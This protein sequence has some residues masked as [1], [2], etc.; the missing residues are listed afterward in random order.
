MPLALLW[1]ADG[2]MRARP[3][4]TPSADTH[5]HVRA[6]M[7]ACRPSN[8]LLDEAGHAKLADFGIARCATTAI[9]TDDSA[10]GTAPC[11][12]RVRH[13]LPCP[14]PFTSPAW[15]PCVPPMHTNSFAA[16]WKGLL[17]QAC[18]PRAEC[19]RLPLPSPLLV[20]GFKG[21]TLHSLKPYRTVHLA[22]RRSA[23]E[24][25]TH[26]SCACVAVSP[27]DLAPEC[28]DGSV[29]R[30]TEKMDVSGVAASSAGNAS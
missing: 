22:A 7:Y 29:Q 15:G 2:C 18:R 30:I 13:A 21:G 19:T 27:A 11:E 14:A 6:H 5:M 10:A 12:P 1:P 23:A 26:G 9:A 17:Q 28:L 4:V 20:V 16:L 25:L 24:V 8:V 3:A